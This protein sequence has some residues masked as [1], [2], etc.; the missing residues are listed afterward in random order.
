MEELALC[1]GKGREENPKVVKASNPFPILFVVL[2]V[3]GGSG[4]GVSADINDE[5]M[6]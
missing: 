2:F 4:G 6:P 5:Q 1:V 3:D